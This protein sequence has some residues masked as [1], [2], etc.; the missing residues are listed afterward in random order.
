VKKTKLGAVVAATFADPKARLQDGEEQPYLVVNTIVGRGKTVWLGS[1]ETWRLRQFRESYHQRFWTELVRYA[2]TGAQSGGDPRV[3]ILMGRRLAA[4]SQATI[5]ARALGRDLR[6]LPATT[7]LS[8]R[9]FCG[10]DTKP[11]ATYRLQ[12]KSEG[13]DFQGWFIVRFPVKDAGD[14]RAELEVEDTG[15]RVTTRFTAIQADP[16]L[17][18]PRPDL[19]SLRQLAI[20]AGKSLDRLEEPSRRMVLEAL[21]R[22]AQYVAGQDPERRLFFNLKDAQRIADCEP[23]VQQREIRKEP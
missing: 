17:D 8:V 9:L 6:P 3:E 7:Q 1:G 11:L 14:Y 21:D 23:R 5:E 19:A 20:P 4:N 12:P 13:S 16:E 22:A 18:D 15:D 2:A 10:V